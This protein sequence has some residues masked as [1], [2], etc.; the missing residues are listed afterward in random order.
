LRTHIA[1]RGEK[2]RLRLSSLLLLELNYLGPIVAVGRYCVTCKTMRNTATDCFA[3]IS[4]ISQT[5]HFLH[6]TIPEPVTPA[7]RRVT[8]PPISADLPFHK[9]VR[10]VMIFFQ[11]GCGEGDASANK[12]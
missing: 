10:N 12:M 1:A 5:T 9:G 4:Q 7:P 3:R 11:K 8:L 2:R 6:I